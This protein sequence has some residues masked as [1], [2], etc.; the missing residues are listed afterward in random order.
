M[1]SLTKSVNEPAYVEMI[2]AAVMYI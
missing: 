1:R 2:C